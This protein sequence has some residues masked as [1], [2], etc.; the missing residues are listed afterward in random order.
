MMTQEEMI[1][2]QEYKM[3]RKRDFANFIKIVM[4]YFPEGILPK[5]FIITQD[6]STFSL[7]TPNAGIDI[8]RKGLEIYEDSAEM[9]HLVDVR[10]I[11]YDQANIRVLSHDPLHFEDYKTRYSLE[12]NP[13]AFVARPKTINKMIRDYMESDYI[14]LK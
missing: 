14:K 3:A 11:Y 2:N 6:E 10:T 13:V 5:G 4:S 12:R 1:Q 9:L 8:T 7:R